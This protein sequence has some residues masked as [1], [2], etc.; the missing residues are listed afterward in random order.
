[1]TRDEKI[2]LIAVDIKVELDYACKLFISNMK[3]DDLEGNKKLY[4]DINRDWKRYIG[5]INTLNRKIK[6]DPFSFEKQLK[7]E[8]LKIIETK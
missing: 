5:K 8:L 6:V 3:R 1:M 7:I 4:D 2:Q